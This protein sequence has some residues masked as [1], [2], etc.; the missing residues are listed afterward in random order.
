MVS[1]DQ[2]QVSPPP[3]QVDRAEGASC[4]SPQE[5]GGHRL[6]AGDGGVP[7]RWG[8]QAGDL[9]ERVPGQRGLQPGRLLQGVR[10]RRRLHPQ[11]AGESA[12]VSEGS[13][14]GV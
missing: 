10:A 8:R 12:R 5:R 6:H 7:L 9:S 14:S 1:P 2:K 11:A 13:R 3:P 4:L